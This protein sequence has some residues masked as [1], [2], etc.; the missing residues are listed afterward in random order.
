MPTGKYRFRCSLGNVGSLFRGARPSTYPL[1]SGLLDQYVGASA[2]YSLRA[3]AASWLRKDV[4]EVRRASDNTSKGFTEKEITDGAMVD[5]VNETVELPLDTASGASAAYSLRNLS[6]GGTSLTSTGD[7]QT[8]YFVFTGA[9]GDTAALNGIKYGY[10]FPH[11]GAKAYNSTP[12]SPEDSQMV[13]NS[14]G[15]WLLFMAETKTYALSAIGTAQYPFDADWTGTDLE[16]AT[17][18]Q[19]RTGSL[20]TQVRRNSD[21]QVRSFTAAE[22]ADGTLTD[23]VGF[24]TLSVALNYTTNSYETF[25]GAS[26]SGFSASNSS[27]TAFAGWIVSSGV[28]G[29]V[30][31]VSFDL[32]ITSGSPQ[33]AFRSAYN[34]SSRRSNS[35]TYTSSG[36]YTATL[37][38]TGDFSFIAFSEGDIPSEFTVSNF[39][40]LA[41]GFVSQW[42]DQSGNDNHATQGT[43]ASQPKIVDAGSLVSGGVTFDGG[44]SLSVS[45]DPV[46]AASSS[47]TF[48][49]FSVQTIP[50][51]EGGYV[52]GNA[53]GSNGSSVYALGGGK[54]TVSNYNFANLDNI[55]R[56]SGQNLLSF[57][58]N[59]G[60]AGLLVNGAGTMTDAGTYDFSAGSSDFIIGNRN[61]GSASAT[62]LTGSISEIIIY[63]SDQSGNRPA[64]ESNIASYYSITLP[65]GS[66]PGSVDGFVSTWYDQSGNTNDAVQA[67]ST[68]QP[69]IVDAGI[70]VTDSN[71]DAAIK[72]TS[73]NDMDFTLDS[74]AA[75]GQQSVFAIIENDVTS[76]D[77]YGVVF[78]AYSTTVDTARSR[79]PYW[80]G[81]PSGG[82]VFSVD[83]LSGY[84]NTD[85][86]PRLYSHIM[87]DTAGGTSTVYRDGTQVDT[88]SITLD[89]NPAFSSGKL[90]GVSQ[91]ATGALYMSEIIYYPSDQS[92]NLEAI[93]T[94]INSHYDIY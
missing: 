8:D 71:G 87:E 48:S 75:D 28:S 73:V 55:P 88:R 60:D 84:Q 39:K 12:P 4:V 15:S 34:N 64:I 82:V 49:G 65:A 2:A 44:H 38:A 27:G 35:I 20:V 61:G 63:N 36:S 29:D 78:K 17:F 62:F 68:S 51:T 77:G 59:N 83:S 43:P 23:W 19:Q 26:S 56:A 67:T 31:K 50:T 42:Y 45:G 9:T 58:Y 91:N 90:L 30:I 46:I 89:T 52:Y 1:F 69:K 33:I 70:L 11:N 22:V 80:F 85:R 74:L 5:W 24:N 40:I 32:N 53:S 79:R 14:N 37:T 41:D 21:D 6:A 54:F 16:N 66:N 47:G 57:V 18:S 7:T 13:R 92:G 72:S 76:Q 93:E 3:L 10:A 86:N 25:T 81:S 94:N